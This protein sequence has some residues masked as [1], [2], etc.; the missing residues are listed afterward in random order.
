MSDESIICKVFA[1][2]GEFRAMYAA[3]A[4]CEENGIS[5]GRSERGKPRG[6]LYGDFD[7]A[8][9][10]NLRKWERESLDGTLTGDARHGPLVLKIRS[11]HPPVDLRHPALPTS[12][13][14]AG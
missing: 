12:D 11:P 14:E 4:W 9:W 8:K 3:E 7:I 1:E 10:H 6:L 5:V 2:T 13:A